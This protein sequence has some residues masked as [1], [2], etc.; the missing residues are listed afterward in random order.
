MRH[1]SVALASMGLLIFLT[2]L[3]ISG[4]GSGSSGGGQQQE[5]VRV[6]AAGTFN[7]SYASQLALRRWQNVPVTV[8]FT[9]NDEFT[10]FGSRFTDVSRD[11][12][13]EWATATNGVVSYRETSDVQQA[14]IVVTIVLLSGPPS[15]GDTLGV[16]TTKRSG[17]RMTSAKIR[18]NI[19]P[20]M[21]RAEVFAGFKATA[22]HEFGHALGIEGHS[23]NENDLMF[24]AHSTSE[25]GEVTQRDLNTLKTAYCDRFGRTR[26]ECLPAAPE[27]ESIET[28]MP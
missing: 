20:N 14:N 22:A 16:T 23:D 9:N 8:S 4:C 17:N 24:A 3:L 11:A 7:P 10:A 21:T 6:C 15:V 28:T 19:W 2:P 26:Q 25:G 13:T 1:K 27:T 5:T 12:F 18:L